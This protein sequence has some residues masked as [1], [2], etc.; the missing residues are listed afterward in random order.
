MTQ[1]PPI[2]GNWARIRTQPYTGAAKWGT[3]IHPVH[4]EYGSDALRIYGRPGYENDPQITPPSGAVPD[5]IETGAP[6]GYTP[7]DIAG[8]DQFASPHEAVSGQVFYQDDWPNWTESTTE[9]RRYPPSESY[10]PLGSPGWFVTRLRSRFSGARTDGFRESNQ[11]P[12]ETVSEGWENKSRGEVA[13]A[14]PSDNSQVFMQTSMTQRY[15]VRNNNAAVSRMTDDPRAVIDSRV[16]GQKLKVY[17]GEQRH[18]DMFPY[19]QD[20]ILRP[21]RYRTAATG[22]PRDM[23]PNEM[24]VTSVIQ[25]TPPPD[26]GPGTPEVDISLGEFGY[27]NEDMGYY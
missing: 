6:W 15:E 27:T 22:N 13:D 14:E 5:F 4:A 3:G 25:R 8:L 12:T 24:R 18:Y 11:L 9:T 21:F 17:S 23:R 26:P 1:K 2:N 10:H 7:E 19:Q 16:A 20:E